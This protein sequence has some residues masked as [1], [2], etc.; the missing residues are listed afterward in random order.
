MTFQPPNEKSFWYEIISGL[1]RL[2]PGAAQA[3]V[4]TIISEQ[5]LQGNWH[6][7]LEVTQ[8]KRTFSPVVQLRILA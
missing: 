2:P 8:I 1:K 6:E 4:K 7:M 3:R 5:I